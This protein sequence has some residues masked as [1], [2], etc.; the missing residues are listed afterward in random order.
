MKIFDF[1]RNKFMQIFQLNVK[2]VT[3]S[4]HLKSMKGSTLDMFIRD[5][6]NVFGAANV[7]KNTARK[8]V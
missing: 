2:F 5:K 3:R 4:F 8:M 7:T 6:I 1:T